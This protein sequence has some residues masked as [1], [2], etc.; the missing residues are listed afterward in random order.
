[1]DNTLRDLERRWQASGSREDYG[2]YR[3]A[4]TR[5]NIQPPDAPSILPELE[6][7]D[8]R[9]AFKYA[10]EWAGAGSDSTSC[11]RIAGSLPDAPDAAPATRADVKRVIAMD[12]GDN[13]GPDW[14]G[15]FELWDGRFLY[16]EAGCDYTGWG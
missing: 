8:W 11:P 14:V 12:E 5:A 3:V 9:Q 15:V 16:V 7:S 4:C 10:G 6:D 13:E 1:M 2:A